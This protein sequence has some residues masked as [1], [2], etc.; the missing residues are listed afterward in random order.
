MSSA[1]AFHELPRANQAEPRERGATQP[2]L[3]QYHHVSPYDRTLVRLSDNCGYIN[4]S[5]MSIIN[6][7]I[8]AQGPL[9][10]TSQVFWQMLNE[11]RVANIVSLCSMRLEGE[12]PFCFDFTSSSEKRLVE[13]VLA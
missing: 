9:P 4:A 7:L 6:G 10:N 13:Q 1:N 12:R 11:H 2:E 3:N 5:H 8:V